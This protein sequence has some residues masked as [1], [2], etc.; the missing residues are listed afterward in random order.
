[1][2]VDHPTFS[3]VPVKYDMTSS[4]WYEAQGRHLLHAGTAILLCNHITDHWGFSCMQ[5]HI[6]KYVQL[7]L[8]FVIS[9]EENNFSVDPP[10]TYTSQM[11]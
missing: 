9:F 1:M 11:K 7:W 3:M 5:I 6:E 2:C 4:I 10:P 8:G